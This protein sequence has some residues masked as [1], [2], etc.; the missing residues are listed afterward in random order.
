MPIELSIEA[1]W[2]KF[3]V[4][5]FGDISDQQYIDLRRT[6]YGGVSALYLLLMRMLDPGDEPTEADLAKMRSIHNELMAFNE[7][8]KTGKA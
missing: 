6:F 1:E 7:A 2:K 5:C 8:V 4:A 3:C